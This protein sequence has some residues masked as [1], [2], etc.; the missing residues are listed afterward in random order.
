MTPPKQ[1]VAKKY[2]PTA[3]E[4]A[5]GD[6]YY[7]R[8]KQKPGALSLAVNDACE[9]EIDHPDPKVAVA[10]AMGAM[11]IADHAFLVDLIEGIVNASEKGELTPETDLTK[12]NAMLSVVNDIAPRDQLEAM[13]A[14]Q[15]AAT[16]QLTMT[17]ARRLN[18]VD[19]I[20][21]QDSA[22]RAFNKLARTF[23]TQMEALKRYR[24]GGQQKMIVEHVTVNE[25]GQ[26]IVGN[27]QGGGREKKR[28]QPH[29]SSLSLP[30]QSE[31]HGHIQAHGQALPSA[32]RQWLVSVPISWRRRRRAE[33]RAQRCLPAW[34]IHP[35]NRSGVSN[36]AS[37]RSGG[38]GHAR[39][40]RITARRLTLRVSAASLCEVAQ[41][42]AC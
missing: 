36:A 41:I 39:S 4:L 11:G 18:H 17:F 30:E 8:K 26:A 28:H 33:G 29:D 40:G 37:V 27:V 24:T 35:R 3:Q 2:E 25:G 34:A 16:H 12:A 22:E 23:T 5:A 1:A 13:L 19:N 14:V 15:I 32:C 20:P 21:Q 9:I 31:M 42:C 6:A 38:E 7:A 10:A